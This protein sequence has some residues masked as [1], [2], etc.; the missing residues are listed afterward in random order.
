MARIALLAI[1]MTVLVLASVALQLQPPRHVDPAQLQWRLPAGLDML[2]LYTVVFKLVEGFDFERAL[3]N[4][5]LINE[6]SIPE[7]LR[8]VA[9]RINNLLE[10]TIR[11]LNETRMNLD[12]AW[13]YFNRSSF[14]ETWTWLGEAERSLRDASISYATL[15]DAT[16]QVSNLGVTVGRFIEELSRV[17]NAIKRLEEEVET[18]RRALTEAREVVETKVTIWVN[19]TKVNFGGWVE[20]RGRLLDVTGAPLEGRVVLVHVGSR[21]YKALVDGEG[22][23]S[24]TS[25]VLEYRRY[26]DV[27]AEF[28]PAG[29][30]RFRYAYSRSDTV[31]VEVFYITPRL[32]VTLSKHEV[33]PLD[34]VTL[35]VNTEPMACL[36]VE[37]LLV[38][39][40]LCVGP[41]GVSNLDFTVNPE[42]PEG[43][44]DVRV[45]VIPQGLI[46]PAGK[47]VQL[48]VYRLNLTLDVG[49]PELLI[50][51][52]EGEVRVNV[53][54]NSNV[55]LCIEGL[56]CLE[57]RGSNPSFRVGVPLTYTR[58]T[59]KVVVVVEPLDPRFR[60]S[61]VALDVKIY[62]PLAV[63][64]LIALAIVAI[65]IPLIA[66]LRMLK[67]R[68]YPREA[69]L[70]EG[71]LGAPRRP[72]T[73]RGELQL[74]LEELSQLTGRLY[75]VSLRANDTFR[76]YLSRLSAAPRGL[77]EVLREALMLLE[78]AL[79]GRPEGAR[80]LLG[81]VVT[82]LRR[83]IEMLRGALS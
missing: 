4:L 57:G 14:E 49:A 3:G 64:T 71:V 25:R 70:P 75:G 8:Y 53:G 48:R 55:S 46:G 6:A 1:T 13:S 69:P 63:V 9:S 65:T 51:G 26:I 58:D 27:Y 20:V 41:E 45:S 73:P 21:V 83:V 23:Y 40:T 80:A 30:D 15:R 34:N 77:V 66:V 36:K 37:S 52:V 28:T 5:S 79:Y 22:F 59:I 35:T 39:K 19:T 56:T 68:G 10:A 12:I 82:L 78:R 29:D 42:L 32:E 72:E 67:P 76:E 44:Y 74:L 81:R 18:L 24:V 43:V 11:S 61:S 47:S 16:R 60:S 38:N 17:E 62:N 33:L 31:T 7:N 2:T 50:A 54:A